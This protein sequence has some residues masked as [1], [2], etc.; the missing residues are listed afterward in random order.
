MQTNSQNIHVS[1][2]MLSVLTLMPIAKVKEKRN[3][4]LRTMNLSL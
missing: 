2:D 3:F 1:H 4:K